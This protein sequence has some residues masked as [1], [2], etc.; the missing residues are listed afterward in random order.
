M[1]DLEKRPPG[2]R[3]PYRVGID[4]ETVAAG[5][6]VALL[7]WIGLTTHQGA[8]TLAAVS[9]RLDAFTQQHAGALVTLRRALE[10]GDGEREKLRVRVRALEL[11][12]VWRRRQESA[13]APGELGA[14]V[15]DLR[16]VDPG[17]RGLGV[18]FAAEADFDPFLDE[19][20]A[21]FVSRDLPAERPGLAA[22]PFG[23]VG[24]G[25]RGGAGVDADQALERATARQRGDDKD[26]R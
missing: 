14:G 21:D 7:S 15:V 6:V 20:G 8:V 17:A 1:G 22:V 2:A 3:W 9:T 16:T 26:R 25:A 19:R 23:Q 10:N 5:L 13:P 24:R 12:G 11:G 4:L 18:T